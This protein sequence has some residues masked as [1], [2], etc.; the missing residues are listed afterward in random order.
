MLHQIKVDSWTTRTSVGR[1][2]SG[3]PERLRLSH[4][5]TEYDGTAGVARA[6]KI[7][8]W[9]QRESFF[10]WVKVEIIEIF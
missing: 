8:N 5:K 1:D 7:P 10:R 2:C 6:A 3:S 9:I 4:Q